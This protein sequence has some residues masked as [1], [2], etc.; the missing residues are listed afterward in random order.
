M[1][2]ETEKYSPRIN[3]QD[4]SLPE[5]KVNKIKSKEKQSHCLQIDKKGQKKD[6]GQRTTQK[7]VIWGKEMK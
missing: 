3:T 4:T 2:R 5:I 7:Y 1:R 6:L